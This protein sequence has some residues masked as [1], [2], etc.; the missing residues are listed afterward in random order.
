MTFK[1][2]SKYKLSSGTTGTNYLSARINLFGHAILVIIAPGQSTIT[3]T[4][5]SLGVAG[6]GWEFDGEKSRPL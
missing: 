4:H 2:K 5:F 6:G 1:A 3:L